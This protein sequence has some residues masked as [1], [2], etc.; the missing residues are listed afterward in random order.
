MC[1]PMRAHWHHLAILLN[2]CF[3]RPTRVHN[4][5]GKLIGSAV[6]AQLMAECHRV[7]W[8]QLTNTIQLVLPSAHLSPQPKWQI[9]R[10]S[11]FC[12][13]HSRKCPYF[14]M[15][16]PFPKIAL[17]IGGSRPHLI[18]DS[19]GHSEVIIQT[20]SQSVQPFLHR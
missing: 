6:F 17:L 12:T 1:H 4:A 13:A 7:Q 19:L 18:H 3:L 9:D 20:S 5:N 11:H 14:T 15:G 16:D 2:L 8:R 10:F